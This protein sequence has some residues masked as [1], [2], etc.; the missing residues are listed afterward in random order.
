M[1]VVVG[2]GEMGELEELMVEESHLLRN[3]SKLNPM[4]SSI[5]HFDL[6]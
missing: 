1:V 2:E 3:Q 4:V 5:R 6:V